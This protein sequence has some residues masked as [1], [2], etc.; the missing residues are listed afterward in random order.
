MLVHKKCPKTFGL[1]SDPPTHLWKKSIRKVHFF[2]EGVPYQ[3]KGLL[4][5]GQ[6][7]SKSNESE[8]KR[9]KVKVQYNNNK[10]SDGNVK[11][12]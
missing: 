4:P 8:G 6:A 11:K 12:S 7:G 3:R 2:Y 5:I 1:A 10:G 9:A